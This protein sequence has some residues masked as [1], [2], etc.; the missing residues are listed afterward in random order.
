VTDGVVIAAL[1]CGGAGRAWQQP[2]GTVQL[3]APSDAGIDELR[4]V[5]ALD[6]DH[7]EFLQRFSRDPMIGEAT[8]RVRGLRP[9]R[10]PTVAHALLRAVSGQLIQARRA[11]GT[12][13]VG[14]VL[15]L[16]IVTD[17]GSAYDSLKAATE[18]SR[19]HTSRILVVI[20]RPGRS[21]RDRAATSSAK[22]R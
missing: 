15:T 18:A 16:V 2:D 17:E 5:L 6:D 10:T 21:P 7:S 19:E 4:F 8:R 3:R 20:K 22:A 1:A 9:V 12:P 13:A 11:I 14:M